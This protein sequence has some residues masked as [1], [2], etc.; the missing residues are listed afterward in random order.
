MEEA[1]SNATAMA[2]ELPQ[3][4]IA[5][6]ASV[7]AQTYR[8]K[9]N[10]LGLS[11]E[12]ALAAR[13]TFREH[14]ALKKK[15]K[16]AADKIAIGK[17]NKK[18]VKNLKAANN[19]LASQ[20]EALTQPAAVPVAADPEP[21]IMGAVAPASPS[22]P[23]P[24]NLGGISVASRTTMRAWILE[25]IGIPNNVMGAWSDRKLQLTFALNSNSLRDMMAAGGMF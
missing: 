19:Q 14:N 11:E 4:V 9:K 24:A 21:Q 15:Q 22:L 23:E 25:N 8:D 20:V 7:W 18:S 10:G 16:R 12:L 6:K 2:D 13:A 17:V 3:A 5:S 1:G